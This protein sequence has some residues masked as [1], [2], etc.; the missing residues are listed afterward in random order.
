MLSK[1][2]VI[3][4]DVDR[5]KG[6]K[7]CGCRIQL[8][9]FFYKMKIANWDDIATINES[10][11]RSFCNENYAKIQFVFIASVKKVSRNKRCTASITHPKSDSIYFFGSTQTRNTHT[12]RRRRLLIYWFGFDFV[13]YLLLYTKYNEKKA[14]NRRR[15]RAKYVMNIM[16]KFNSTIWW[17]KSD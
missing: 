16:T 10:L 6:V 15:K 1:R 17:I 8:K 2:M 13:L 12:I 11:I 7:I 3:L 4:L 14:T 5:K 9:L